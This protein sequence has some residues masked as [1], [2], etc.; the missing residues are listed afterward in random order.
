MQGNN[1]KDKAVIRLKAEMHLYLT[2]QLLAS[3][4]YVIV[5]G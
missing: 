3:I 1:N 5:T 2:H 4:Y